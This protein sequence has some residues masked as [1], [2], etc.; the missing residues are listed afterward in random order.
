SRELGPATELQP[1]LATVLNAMRSLIDF[2]GGSVCLVEDHHIRIAASDPPVSEEVLAA[3]LPV[4]K[5]LVGLAVASGQPQYSRALDNDDRVDPGLRN[6]GSNAAMKSYL[7]V[8]LV[9]LGWVIG[10]LEVDS[11]KVD[12]F[13]AD[14]LA[15]L[16]GLATQVA[17]AIESARRYEHVIE[18]ERLKADFLSRISHELRTPLTIISGFTTT[19]LAYDER[20]SGEQRRDMLDR[21]GSAVSRLERLIDDVLTVTGFEAGVVAPDPTE[22]GLAELLTDAAHDAADPVL[23]TIDV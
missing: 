21:M 13:D 8:P 9:C 11:E 2:R 6:L 4:G 10:V 12:A 15:V 3:R 5:G 7:T 18:L 16:Q 19:L 14:D 1:V 22:V 20:L 23:V 17:G